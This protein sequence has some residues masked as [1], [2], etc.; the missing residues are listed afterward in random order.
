MNARVLTALAAVAFLLVACRTAP[1]L[2]VT[3]APVNVPVGQTATLATVEQAIIRAGNGLG[4][5][6]KVEKPGLIVGNLYLRDHQ[7][8][9]DIP[10]TTS[11]YS[12]I[13]RSSVNLD[14][15][16]DSIHR[17]YNGWVQNLDKAIRKNLMP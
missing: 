12:I 6:M 16:G 9:V 11:S 15:S 8:V 14:Q 7:A 13:Y 5:Q 4:W 10:F 1:I 2:N 17:N 3:D